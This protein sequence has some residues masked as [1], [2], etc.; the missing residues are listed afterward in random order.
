MEMIGTA[1]A[2]L[3]NLEVLV[4]A[5]RDLGARHI[6][7]GVQETH[8]EIVGEAL[9]WTLEQGL[10]ADFTDEVKDAWTAVYTVLAQTAIDG[11]N[12]AISQQSDSDQ[13]RDSLEDAI[14]KN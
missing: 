4:P 12:S 3:N 13:K 5:V 11:A 14:K 10:G 7:Y 2:G 1:V 8:Y 6:G 9:L